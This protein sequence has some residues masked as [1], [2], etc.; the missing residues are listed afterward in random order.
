M[1]VCT[2]D[3]LRGG[4][5][6]KQHSQEVNSIS[7]PGDLRRKGRHP[8]ENN[9]FTHEV[10]IGRPCPLKG[11][12]SWGIALL[13]ITIIL[14]PSLSS[15]GI[16]NE[17]RTPSSQGVSIRDVHEYFVRVQRDRVWLQAVIHIDICQ[18]DSERLNGRHNG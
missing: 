16:S 3:I 7:I 8:V 15:F 12:G 17:S 2:L 14:L 18:F 4:S 10:Y 1:T 6:Q 9:T 13:S 5:T 11:N